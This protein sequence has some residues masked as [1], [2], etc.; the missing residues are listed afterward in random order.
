M[1]DMKKILVLLT[2]PV[3]TLNLWGTAT[4]SSGTQS[5]TIAAGASDRYELISIALNSNAFTPVPLTVSLDM[6][7]A[8]LC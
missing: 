3:L 5:V 1:T 7:H 2:L 6:R 4:E 8:R